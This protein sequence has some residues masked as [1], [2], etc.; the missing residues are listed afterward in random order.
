M[1]TKIKIPKN[2]RGWRK[3]GRGLTRMFDKVW[4]G[5]EFVPVGHCHKDDDVRMYRCVIRKSG[6]G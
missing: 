3:V 1:S 6:R 5:R 2:H 4:N